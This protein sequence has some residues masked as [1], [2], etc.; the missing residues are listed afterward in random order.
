MQK[1]SV[2]IQLARL[3]FLLCLLNFVGWIASSYMT[4]ETLSWYHQLPNSPLTPP[5]WVFGVVWSVLFFMMALSYFLVWGRA[6]PRWYAIQ[7][8]INMLWSFC[9]FY[10]KLPILGFICVLLLIFS[11]FM[12]IKEFYRHSKVAG[13]LLLPTMIWCFFALYLNGFIVFGIS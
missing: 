12:C 9:F 2:W 1:K 3:L 8:G 6:S 7:L 11:L 10:L 13:W 5:N 4:P